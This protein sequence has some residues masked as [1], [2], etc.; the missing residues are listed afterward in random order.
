MGVEYRRLRPDELRGRSYAGRLGFGDS[1][2]AAEIERGLERTWLRPEWTLVAVE[3]GDF[4]SQV[5]TAPFMM[6]WNGR[7]IGCGAVTA[8]STLPTHRRRGHLRELMRRSFDAMREQD[9]PV[10][11]L[12]ASMAA[13]YQRFGYGLGYAPHLLGFDPRHLRFVDEIA[14]PGRTRMVKAGEAFPLLADVYERFAAPRTL[15]FRREEWW[16]RRRVLERGNPDAAPWLVTLY[17][18]AGEPRGYVIYGIEQGDWTVPGPNQTIHVHDFVWLTPAA[19]RAL[20]RHLIGH[21]L[22]KEVRMGLLP[23][24]DPLFHHVQEPRLLGDRVE[25]GTWLRIVDLA[26]AL[27]GRGYDGGG[28]LVF[29]FAD[30]LCPWNAGDWELTVEGGAA[31]LK[32]AGAEPDLRLTP[33]PLAMLADGSVDATTLAR[34]GLIPAAEP[35]ALRTADAI[36]HTAHA[37]YCADHF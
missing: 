1:T 25:D 31:R 9:Q 7:D 13:I 37:P 10:A 17:E 24:D 19:H 12:W 8:V 21:D 33:R 14:V 16:W 15:M 26:A 4:A 35:R 29:S 18:E 30:D 11:M 20:V 22:V 5:T 32:P 36:F 23:A 34:M 27:E 3:D 28:R 2:A 6:R